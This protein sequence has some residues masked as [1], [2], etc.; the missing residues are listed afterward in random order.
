MIRVDIDPVEVGVGEGDKHLMRIPRTHLHARIIAHGR[1]EKGE[2]QVH[3]VQFSGIA[4]LKDLLR[5]IAAMRSHFDD[6]AALRKALQK[7]APRSANTAIGDKLRR[8][9]LRGLAP[10]NDVM[11]NP[12]HEAQAIR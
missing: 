6:V 12:Q 9:R 3:E 8:Q 7:L 5:E 11:S 1:F 2:I 4:N 10:M